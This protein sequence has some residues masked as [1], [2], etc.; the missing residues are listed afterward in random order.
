ME[1]TQAGETLLR[2]G[3][4]QSGIFTGDAD[5]LGKFALQVSHGNQGAITRLISMADRAAMRADAATRVQVYN[6]ALKATG[7]EMQAELAAME[8]MNFSKRGSSPT[9][10]HAARMIPFLNAQMQSLNV[11]VKAMR[12][13]ATMEEQLH[14]RSKFLKTAGMLS[15]FSFIYALGMEDDE[16]YKSATA[17]ERFSNYFVPTP[18]GTL[19]VPIPYEVG[20]LF[21]ALPEAA[22]RAMRQGLDETDWKALGSAAINTIP[23]GS[24]Y[25]IP[26]AGKPLIELAL[27][28]SMFTGRDIESPVQQKLDAAERYNESTTELAK[29]LGSVAGISPLKIEHLVRG[30][31]GGIPIAVASLA[32]EV[33]SDASTPERRAS[34]T[35]LFGTLI[36]DPIG[37]GPL[38]RAYAKAAAIEQAGNTYDKLRK[39]GK[40]AAAQK[41]LEDNLNVLQAEKL[42]TRF[43][44]DMKQAN[45][46]RALVMRAE[47]LSSEEKRRRLDMIEQ[48][49]NQKA[50]LFTQAVKSVATAH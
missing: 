25:G 19:K 48:V 6:D 15:A 50:D 41:Y 2:K 10:Q 27:N 37:R 1:G 36:A 5:D 12:G 23:G 18:V 39:D 38:D 13:N 3:V 8:M 49:R 35:P 47:K 28:R 44:K 17:Q 31:V 42:H 26:Q 14:I 4:T 9:V 24:S 20:L 11:L 22:A 32:N 21:K 43:E 46:A 7:S 29:M 45:D 34:Q 16:E 30:Y 33:L 40:H